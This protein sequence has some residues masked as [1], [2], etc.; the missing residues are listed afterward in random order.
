[1]TLQWI[2]VKTA[3]INIKK[4][5]L[6]GRLQNMPKR[7]EN[8]G[9]STLLNSSAAAWVGF[10]HTKLDGNLFHK[11]NKLRCRMVKEPVGSH[12]AMK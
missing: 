10:P 4:V 8:Q 11:L 2:L 7:S 6:E 5:L 3:T 12:T 9:T 1:M